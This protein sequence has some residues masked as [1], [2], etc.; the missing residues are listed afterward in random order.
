MTT[1]KQLNDLCR[2]R[3]GDQFAPYRFTDLQINQWINDAI[4]D[5]SLQFRREVTVEIACQVGTRAY[6]LQSIK[7]LSDIL[8]VVYIQTSAPEVCL[9]RRSQYDRRG[10]VGLEVYDT[11]R[12][13]TAN[14]MLVIG[15]E[16]STGDLV[17]LTV[18]TEHDYLASDEDLTTLPDSHLELITL[19][20]RMAAM[21]AQY[22][23]AAAQSDASSL[24]LSS[25][26]N[27]ADRAWNEYQQ[28][29]KEYLAAVAE[30][31]TICVWQSKMGL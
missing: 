14:L 24:L 12:D 3:L 27:N 22:A 18:A 5:Y 26:A 31:G 16:P 9:T 1:R 28:K 2:R 21:Q 4:A 6:S 30:G 20:V 19:F 25:L 23:Q 13:E 15:I 10:F 29:K 8:S 17:H 7:G 11:K